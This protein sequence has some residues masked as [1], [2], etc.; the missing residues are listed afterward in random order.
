MRS[1]CRT[2]LHAPMTD[3]HQKVSN[4]WSAHTMLTNRMKPDAKHTIPVMQSRLQ[5]AGTTLSP[6]PAGN[7]V[8]AEHDSDS[9][10][11]HLLML[12]VC[13]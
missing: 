12:V 10:L 1:A 5:Q 3:P 2:A 9:V 6:V 8:P 11:L 13:H 7:S 4:S